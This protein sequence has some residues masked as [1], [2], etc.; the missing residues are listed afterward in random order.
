MKYQESKECEID[1]PS[2]FVV[3][4]RCSLGSTKTQMNTLLSKLE[5]STDHDIALIQSI[6]VKIQNLDCSHKLNQST[7]DILSEIDS[8]I[9]ECKSQFSNEEKS[10]HSQ[11]S[12]VAE[13]E[14]HAEELASQ[15][16]DLK[17]EESDLMSKIK[18]YNRQAEERVEEIDNVE[19]EQIEQVTRLQGTV[20]L[21][22]TAS[23]IKWH[24]DDENVDLIKGE[25]DIPSKKV[26]R[27][28]CFREST[29]GLEVTDALW[30][31]MMGE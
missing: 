14:A 13:L 26:T 8:K 5:T 24:Y 22:A 30:D 19:Y 31:M 25:V 11:M 20:T 21:M 16:R 18:L 1:A 15:L 29:D 6:V 2:S 7:E 23:G 9:V 27:K 4:G 12:R 17:T 28:F 3:K 10:L